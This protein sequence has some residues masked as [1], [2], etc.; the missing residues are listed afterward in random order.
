MGVSKTSDHI[1]IKIRM[2][3]PIQEPPVSYKV[4]NQDLKD[5]YVLC[6]FNIMM[7]SQILD[8]G[9]IKNQWPYPNQD[10]GAKPQSGTSSLLQSPKW[11]LKDYGCIKGQWSYPNQNHDA[12]PHS[13]TSSVFWDPKWGLKGHGCSLH[14]QN[15]DKKQKFRSWVYQRPMTISK[16]RSRCQTQ[17][18]NLQNLHKPHMYPY[19]DPDDNPLSGTSSILQHS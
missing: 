10:Q 7:E 18:R 4:P 14:L 13:G 11:W 5:M 12:K 17:V 9:C 2:Q 15:Q 1:Q 16:S 19:Q 6:P 8:N 3:H